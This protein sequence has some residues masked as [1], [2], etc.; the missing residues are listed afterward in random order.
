MSTRC[1]SFQRRSRKFTQVT[2]RL[3]GDVFLFCA[4]LARMERH[5]PSLLFSGCLGS[6]TPCGVDGCVKVHAK[7]TEIHHRAARDSFCGERQ[8]WRIRGLSKWYG[9]AEAVIPSSSGGIRRAKLAETRRTSRSHTACL[10]TLLALRVCRKRRSLKWPRL[11]LTGSAHT[12]AGLTERPMA[13]VLYAARRR[14][15]LGIVPLRRHRDEDFA[16]FA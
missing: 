12:A 4:R 3:S 16:A 1:Y 6:A 14:A 10:E 2:I 15:Q 7:E 5:D 9:A 13:A 11:T 8:S